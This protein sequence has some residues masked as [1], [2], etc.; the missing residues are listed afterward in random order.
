VPTKRNSDMRE[1]YMHEV[2]ALETTGRVLFV[3]R[4]AEYKYYNMDAAVASAI[5]KIQQ[6]ENL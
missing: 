5:G 3:G 1:S 4:L 2:E 6:W